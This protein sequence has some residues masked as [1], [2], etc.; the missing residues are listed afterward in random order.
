MSQFLGMISADGGWSW[1]TV[2]ITEKNEKVGELFKSLAKKLF[3]MDRITSC[4]DK[5]NGVKNHAIN[6]VPLCKYISYLLG[7]SNAYDKRIPTQIML[8]S[9]NEKLMFIRGLSLDGYYVEQKM[10]HVPYC[11]VSKI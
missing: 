11:G 2:R 1:P 4:T 7:N 9:K 8:G 5:R 10:S 6:S 3:N